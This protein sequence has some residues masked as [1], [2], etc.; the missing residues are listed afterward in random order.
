MPL[1]W[2]T[3]FR[4]TGWGWRSIIELALPILFV[5]SAIV[6][7]PLSAWLA[8]A[9]DRS[10]VMWFAFGLWL[11][12]IA[13][14]LLAMAP[15]G[16][17]RVCGE[18]SRG[19][20]DTCVACGSQLDGSDRIPVAMSSEARSNGP[21]GPVAVPSPP[22]TRTG[23]NLTAVGAVPAGAVQPT[24][25]APVASIAPATGRASADRGTTAKDET[26][27]LATGVFVGGSVHLSL[28]ARY[29]VARRKRTFEVLGPVDIAPGTLRL[30]HPLTGLDATV[31][32]DR[33][34]VTEKTTG[35][36]KFVMV[37]QAL[38]VQDGIDLES[39]FGN[40]RKPRARPNAR[41][42]AS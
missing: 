24:V 41:P 29:A 39:A 19:W 16:R 42:N 36:P 31:V 6:F 21:I 2:V 17:C 18:R 4:R 15:P 13:P 11:G 8:V 35:R 20:L 27:I 38:S 12:P 25:V 7:G 30:E 14:L 37:F 10:A 9:R 32:A 22:V 5:I 26:E 1:R 34:V 3:V 33:L 40:R 28:G 23:P